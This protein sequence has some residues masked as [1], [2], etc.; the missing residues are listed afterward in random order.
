MRQIKQDTIVA[1]FD[2][3]QHA[4]LDAWNKLTQEQ[5]DE[6]DEFEARKLVHDK[7]AA[8]IK[9]AD[10]RLAEL[11]RQ[12]K[13]DEASAAK[14]QADLDQIV[15][16]QKADMKAQAERMA[17]A[18]GDG[19]TGKPVVKDLDD[20]TIK[21]FAQDKLDEKKRK[22][23][24]AAKLTEKDLAEK[25]AADKLAAEKVKEEADAKL[26]AEKAEAKKAEKAAAD[27]LAE[28][29][30]V[31]RVEKEK[32]D[33]KLAEE[34]LATEKEADKVAA[35]V[36]LAAEKEAARI[37]KEK[38]DQKVADEKKSAK[39]EKK[40]AAAQLAGEKKETK[41][42]EKAAAAKLKE[43]KA[44]IEKEEKEI[45]DKEQKAE[46]LKN[47]INKAPPGV[48]RIAKPKSCSCFEAFSHILGYE[49]KTSGPL[50]KFRLDFWA[51]RNRNC[52]E[53]C[54]HPF[55]KFEV[56][57]FRT[58]VKGK[59]VVPG[60]FP[61]HV[62]VE[63]GS[64]SGAHE[65]REELGSGPRAGDPT[66]QD[67]VDVIKADIRQLQAGQA[68]TDAYLG[69]GQSSAESKG[70]VK[71]VTGTQASSGKR[72]T[73]VVAVKPSP[74]PESK[75]MVVKPV[76]AKPVAQPEVKTVVV[77][78]AA[79][80]ESKTISDP[81]AAS[82]ELQ[83]AYNLWLVEFKN[84]IKSQR[85]AL[86]GDRKAIKQLN[87]QLIKTLMEAEQNFVKAN[88]QAAA[89]IASDSAVDMRK[90]TFKE[91]KKAETKMPATSFLQTIQKVAELKMKLKQEYREEREETEEFKDFKEKLKEEVSADLE[92]EIQSKR[93]FEK[94]LK[95]HGQEGLLGKIKEYFST[96]KAP[97]HVDDFN[98]VIP[99]AQI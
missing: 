58:S 41:E 45:A 94:K 29:K 18:K 9:L 77:Q 42:E 66:L 91:F 10:E 87:K 95:E 13:E 72:V 2:K 47:H 19:K 36:K 34:K 93:L 67:R 20:E 11:H 53:Y 83:A 22:E 39:E 38:I 78:P 46:N 7:E 50:D 76:I 68:A 57:A 14:K 40:A 80:P 96:K 35:E 69:R 88:E 43:E 51:L 23:E 79:K 75:S 28:E 27:K 62:Y 81:K 44:R 32:V 1:G 82:A 33:Q 61:D 92:E 70:Q 16:E 63:A 25:L 4:E 8:M 12:G 65:K 59:L 15:K 56:D 52:L 99:P 97:V 37:E 73:K 74:K 90:D 31:A 85:A 60:N 21:K 55:S 30:K 6:R 3:D 48:S 54:T 26:G 17:A 84:S 5:R 86:N 98:T 64:S 89:A 71:S 24:E 49:T